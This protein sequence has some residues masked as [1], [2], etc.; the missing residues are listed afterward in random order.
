M[1]FG[2]VFHTPWPE[3]KDPSRL[4]E[5]MTEQIQLGEEL[6]FSSTWMAEHHFSRYGLGASSTVLASSIAARTK[7][8]RIGMAVL[9]PPLHNPIR[10]AEET[11]MLD[12]TSGGRLDVGFGRGSAAYEYAGLGIDREES[13]LR[14][15]EAIEVVCGLWTTRD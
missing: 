14:F 1:K 5:E 13:Q 10:L 11:A 9:V 2:L 15:R 8:I 6:G 7:K 4:I 12:R 3:G